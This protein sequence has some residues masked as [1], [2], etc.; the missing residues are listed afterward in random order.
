M[1][2]F[3]KNNKLSWHEY[4]KEVFIEYLKGRYPGKNF[5]PIALYPD[6][7]LIEFRAYPEGGD[8]ERDLIRVYMH[9][10][11]DKKEAR[12]E[13][14]YFFEYIRNDYEECVNKVIGQFFEKYKFFCV[15]GLHSMTYADV[16]KT[17]YTWEDMKHNA[18]KI[19]IETILFTEDELDKEELVNKMEELKAQL[20]KEQF[21]GSVVLYHLNQECLNNVDLEN[22][23]NYN[24]RHLPE[25]GV[26]VKDRR[27]M[28]IRG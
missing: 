2:L 11:D 3:K 4:T 22:Y 24:K 20:E 25:I 18:I 16:V 5:L 27:H 21:Y 23:K 15:R 8:P 7:N 17:E 6:V 28:V 19:D 10:G 13:D 9:K 1:G 14:N 26:Q 12:I